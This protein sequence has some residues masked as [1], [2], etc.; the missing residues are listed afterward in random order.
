VSEPLRV[1]ATLEVEC[2]DG[3]T[4]V[5]EFP[6]VVPAGPG[7]FTLTVQDGP[8]ARTLTKR[9]TLP[10]PRTLV[11]GLSGRLV[12]TV[13]PSGASFTHT[14]LKRFKKEDAP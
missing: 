12:E 5:Y 9:P 1:K 6:H 2:D 8:P 7:G 14:V 4:W 10:P 11:F 13:D 3:I